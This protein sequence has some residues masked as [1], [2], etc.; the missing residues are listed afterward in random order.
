MIAIND[1]YADGRDMSWLWDV[2]FDTLRPT[3]V[4]MVSGCARLRYGA[5]PPV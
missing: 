5:A 1:Q 3:G 4:A 2:D